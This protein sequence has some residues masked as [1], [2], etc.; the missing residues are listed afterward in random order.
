MIFTTSDLER[1]SNKLY[2]PN[3]A[4]YEM[5]VDPNH[6]D[7]AWDALEKDKNNYLISAERNGAIHFQCLLWSP[8]DILLEDAVRKATNKRPGFR[9]LQPDRARCFPKEKAFE[10]LMKT[11]KSYSKLASPKFEKDVLQTF[12]Q[13]A[14]DI[15]KRTGWPTNTGFLQ[16]QAYAKKWL[17]KERE[18]AKSR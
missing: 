2:D 10:F 6:I 18:K 4:T 12:Q 11:A 7:E 17:K 14:K 8:S 15:E 3:E 13:A 5:R 9:K 16:M 1:Y